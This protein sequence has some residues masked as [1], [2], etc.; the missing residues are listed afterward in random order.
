MASSNTTN[1][2]SGGCDII[3]GPHVLWT[4]ISPIETLPCGAPS[5]IAASSL[6]EQVGVGEMV[7]PDS[8]CLVVQA[9]L[10]VRLRAA[11]NHGCYRY[12]R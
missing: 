5:P 10:Q 12:I 7:L 6:A 2:I 3:A 1:S 11:G 9:C 4:W 8:A